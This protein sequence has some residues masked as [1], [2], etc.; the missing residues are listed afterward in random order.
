M[1]QKWQADHVK[2]QNKEIPWRT[3]APTE[4][5]SAGMLDLR[6][7]VVKATLCVSCHVGNHAEGKVVTHEMYAAGHPPLPPFELASYMEGEPRHW[8]YATE[9][10]FF[11]SVKATDT[12]KL[13]HF[14]PEK[15]E[16]YLARHYAVGAIASL[17]AEAEVL[18]GDAERAQKAQE[19]L[20]YAR[21]DCYACHHELRSPSDRQ[22]R[23]YGND[24]P[25]RAPLR[26]AAGVPAGLVAKHAE[27]IEAGG[28]K[29]KAAGFDEKWSNLRKAATA[30]PFGDPVK[31]QAEAKA[32]REWCDAFLKAQGDTEAP[33]YTPE[34]TARLQKMLLESATGNA[35]LADPEVAMALAWGAR[36][37]S[38]TPDAKLAELAKVIPL[39]VRTD[40][41]S[42]KIGDDIFPAQAKFPER[43][44][45]VSLFE[46][47][48]F[49]EA[50]KAGF[51]TP[52]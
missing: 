16:T 9:L 10:K 33:L 36:T 38:K 44:K 50:F 2:P 17:R 43:M 39:N 6:N 45:K 22:K 3:K 24:P 11:E 12:W 25:G 8:G 35:A 46:G 41:F 28:L 40:P 31:L 5:Y 20:D 14:H 29:A 30:K 26:A 27:G 32:I 51:G 42:Q 18:Q 13:F 15:T 48:K 52:K 23:G 19:P 4:K 34:Q 7:P 47:P 1:Y 37:I 21:F 49:A